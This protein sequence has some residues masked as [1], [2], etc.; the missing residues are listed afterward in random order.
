[1]ENDVCLETTT[2]RLPNAE[3]ERSY[4]FLTRDIILNE[5]IRRA[6]PQHRTVGEIVRDDIAQPL[7]LEDQ[8]TLGSE[9]MQQKHKLF[10]LVRKSPLWM[11][12]HI[13]NFI[14]RKVSMISCVAH[15]VLMH[16]S[17]SSLSSSSLFG[18][19]VGLLHSAER[20]SCCHWKIIFL[21]SSKAIDRHWSPSPLLHRDFFPS[22]SR[23]CRPRGI[24]LLV[25]GRH[26]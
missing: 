9:T 20:F 22:F 13:F 11:F 12:L 4:H 2:T 8:L 7:G 24:R 16:V 14:S 21:N 18:R 5:I 26:V 17:D 15:L 19:S 25:H 6:D 3:P 1:M 23:T 10:P